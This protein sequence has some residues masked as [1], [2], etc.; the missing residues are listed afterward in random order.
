MEKQEHKK[1][2]NKFQI[3][4][5]DNDLVGLFIDGVVWLRE[6]VKECKEK[7]I[8][9]EEIKDPPTYCKLSPSYPLIDDRINCRDLFGLNFK[10]DLDH[11]VFLINSYVSIFATFYMYHFPIKK[12]EE[13][14]LNEEELSRESI[15]KILLD[16]GM[17]KSLHKEPSGE[18]YPKLMV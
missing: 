1:Y 7:N 13:L 8:E 4:D 3:S 17:S 12:T 15:L 9:L 14:I 16:D 5:Y 11:D 6:I 2:Y 10:Y 18:T